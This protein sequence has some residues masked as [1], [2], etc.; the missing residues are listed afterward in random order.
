MLTRKSKRTK[1]KEI[2]M[3]IYL[4]ENLKEE[5]YLDIN[6]NIGNNKN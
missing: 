4:V 5:D 6:L 3:R 1:Y 2:Y